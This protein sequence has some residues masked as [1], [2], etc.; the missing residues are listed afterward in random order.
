MHPITPEEDAAQIWSEAYIRGLEKYTRGQSEHRTAFPTAGASWYA[1]QLREEALD[2]IAYGHHLSSR[3]A[4]IRSL[5][6]LLR[7]DDSMTISMAATIVDHLV[8][9]HPPKPH[10]SAPRHHD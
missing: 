3:L 7:E 2:S 9:D 4:S 1:A 6:R 5:A 8:G 10:Q